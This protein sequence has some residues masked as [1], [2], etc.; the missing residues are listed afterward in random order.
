MTDYGLTATGVR[1]KT[2]AEMLT[3]TEAFMRE[4]IAPNLVLDETTPEG[5][6][7]RIA[8]D[9]L[10]QCWELVEAAAGALDP[11]NAEDFLLVGLCKL[12]GIARFAA[13]YGHVAVTLTFDQATTIAANTLLLAVSG[14]ATNLWSNDDDIVVTGA[15]SDSYDFTSTTASSDAT[16]LAGTLTVIATP[17]TGLTGATNPLDATPGTDIE[18]L[19]ALRL[20]REA[21]LA[22]TGKATVAAIRADVIEVDGVVDIRVIENDTDAAVDGIPP[23]AIRVV[24][25]DGTGTDADD[26]ELAQAIYDAKAAGTITYGLETGDAEDPWG[27]VKPQLF[28]RAEQLE[29]YID[30]EVTGTASSDDIKTAFIAA[31]D[32]TIA[33]DLL[34]AALVA[35]AFGVSG[36]T[37]VLSL[38]LGLSASPT[39]TADIPAG[40]DQVIV[41]D[42][43]RIGVTLS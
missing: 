33:N 43:S 19:S 28:D 42:S 26:D 11:D 9:Q 34:Y 22:G 39:G 41:L 2:F 38:T 29:A 32:V 23:R 6:I 31:H 13:D 20:R 14:E 17:K 16:A 12:T 36:V 18:S 40:V 3:D 1:R 21:S 8:L 37:N 25:W 24:V 5:N 27:D 15:G 4:R 35:A 10:D 7:N 30:V